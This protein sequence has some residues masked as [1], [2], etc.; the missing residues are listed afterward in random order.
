[1]LFNI[2]TNIFFL[3]FGKK[4]FFCF[5]KLIFKYFIKHKNVVP[6]LEKHITILIIQKYP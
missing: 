3:F 6:T 4:N 5:K 2:K 1:M